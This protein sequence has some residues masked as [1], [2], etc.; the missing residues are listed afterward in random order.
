MRKWI[1]YGGGISGT[2][3]GL[4]KKRNVV[5]GRQCQGGVTKRGTSGVYRVERRKKLV[6][7]VG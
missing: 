6:S 4:D 5:G 7:S 2:R 1:V 3:T